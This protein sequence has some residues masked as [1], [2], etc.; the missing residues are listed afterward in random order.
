MVSDGRCQRCQGCCVQH[1][2]QDGNIRINHAIR[3]LNCG[4]IL[5]TTIMAMQQLQQL[6]KKP[7]P[8]G[9]YTRRGKYERK[10]THAHI[11]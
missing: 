10:V 2:L 4:N 9:K 1:Q 8:S 5:D 6:G 7:T 11:Q 3:C